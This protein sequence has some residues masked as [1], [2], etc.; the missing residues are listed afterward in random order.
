MTL[1][2]KQ[3]THQITLATLVLISCILPSQIAPA[4]V[5]PIKWSNALRQNR[6]W[7][8][9]AEALRIAGNVLLYQRDSGGW[10][11]NIDMAA[12]LTEAQR[13]KLLQEKGAPDSTIDNTATYTQLIFL[14]RTYQAGHLA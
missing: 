7:Y 4:Q 12:V 10:P 9:S 11:K 6:D 14:A 5:P 2:R 8:G 1:S 13:A 3:L